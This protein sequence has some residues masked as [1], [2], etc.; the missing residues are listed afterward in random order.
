MMTHENY[1]EQFMPSPS[2][3]PFWPGCAP[4]HP[5]HTPAI[6]FIVGFSAFPVAP[7]SSIAAPYVR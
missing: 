5:P 1:L 3:Y 7:P 2:L 4:K 6:D